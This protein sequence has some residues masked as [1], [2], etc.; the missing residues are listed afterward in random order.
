MNNNKSDTLSGTNIWSIFM[1]ESLNANETKKIYS[2]QFGRVGFYCIATIVDYAIA[3]PRDIL[4]Q[5]TYLPTP[6]LG[7]DITQRQFL[8]EV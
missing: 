5:F 2:S 7:Q 6:P 3:N 8:S 1:H 4:I